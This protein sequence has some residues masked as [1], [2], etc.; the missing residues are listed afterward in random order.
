MQ[1]GDLLKKH[2]RP[3]PPLSVLSSDGDHFM[4][5]RDTSFEPSRDRLCVWGAA[6]KYDHTRSACAQWKSLCSLVLVVLFLSSKT[7]RT[8]L[9]QRCTARYSTAPSER[10][11]SRNRYHPIPSD[12]PLP[13]ASA[14]SPP[15]PLSSPPLPLALLPPL[16]PTPHLA[17]VSFASNRRSV[18]AVAPRPG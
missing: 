15:P 13:L 4:A 1:C 8:V 17:T 5:L 7:Q 18:R 16:A 3:D 6:K 11:R 10:E 9:Y 12:R 2:H 14:P